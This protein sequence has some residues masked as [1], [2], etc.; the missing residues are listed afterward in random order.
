MSKHLQ[1]ICLSLLTAGA[2][3][4]GPNLGA[5]A[6]APTA[7]PGTLLFNAQVNAT[8]PAPPAGRVDNF[9]QNKQNEPSI[10]RDPATGALIAG[11]NDEIDEPLCTGS[12][13]AGSP[14]SCPFVPGVG[15]SGVYVSTNGG[16][17]WTQPAFPNQC[18]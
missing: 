6:Q 1:V 3:I 13:T 16:Q 17:G 11:S 4:V 10:I 12:G 15:N 9:P 8:A 14:G 18:G 2:L 5:S 7:S